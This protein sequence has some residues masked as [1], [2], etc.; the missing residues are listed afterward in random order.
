MAVGGDA[1]WHP[2]IFFRLW[3]APEIADAFDEW[4]RSRHGR[5]LVEA[6][7]ALHFGYF[8]EPAGTT[9]FR[10]SGPTRM[11]F[12]TSRSIEGLFAWM[13]SAEL[14]SELADGDQWMADLREVDGQPFSANVYV[15]FAV[16]GDM[17]PPDA[18]VYAVRLEVPAER[19][20]EFDEWIA[21]HLARYGQ[22][23]GVVLARAF[24]ARRDDVPVPLY[25]SPGNR[26]VR[27]EIDPPKLGDAL[28]SPELAHLLDLE[29]R[30][31]RQASYVA[32]DVFVHRFHYDATTR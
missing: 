12:Y 22:V 21:T 16:D 28:T 31:E 15:P 1:R 5:V 2:Q 8:A 6:P 26:M 20:R 17:A 24:S 3:P 9:P 11:D 32:R 25:R 29:Q 7:G 4:Q 30:W 18:A 27:V 14:A 23:P 13:R 10:T 19:E